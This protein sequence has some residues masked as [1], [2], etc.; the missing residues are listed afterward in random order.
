MDHNITAL[1]RAFQLADSGECDSVPHS[2]E[3]LKAEGYPTSPRRSISRRTTPLG[4]PSLQK[5][6]TLFPLP[7]LGK[8]KTRRTSPPAGDANAVSGIGLETSFRGRRTILHRSAR[9][10]APSQPLWP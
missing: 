9:Q 7:S 2:K 8:Q 10:A 4:P 6:V 1:E 5:P 3:R